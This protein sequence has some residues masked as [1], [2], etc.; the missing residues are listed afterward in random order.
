M[1][2]INYFC[3]SGLL[4][5]SIIGTYERSR[6]RWPTLAYP[7]PQFSQASCREMWRWMSNV[8]RVH[9]VEVFSWGAATWWPQR[10][11]ADTFV[12]CLNNELMF[13]GLTKASWLFECVIAPLTAGSWSIVQTAFEAS[14]IPSR[15]LIRQLRDKPIREKEV[16]AITGW[17]EYLNLGGFK[18]RGHQVSL[19]EVCLAWPVTGKSLLWTEHS[20]WQKSSP[21][22]TVSRGSFQNCKEALI[23]LLTDP[24]P[25]LLLTLCSYYIF[26]SCKFCHS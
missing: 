12:I 17:E 16:W 7:V 3:R 10:K 18:S 24:D 22:A 4:S 1:F 26:F 20:R 9:T 15:R 19:S 21:M 25:R 23:L 14:F 5:G 13:W 8:E 11:A 2:N 6:W